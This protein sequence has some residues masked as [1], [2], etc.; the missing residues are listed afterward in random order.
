MNAIPRNFQS[1]SA[2]RPLG[3]DVDGRQSSPSQ[4]AAGHLYSR[5][6]F[7]ACSIA[8]LTGSGLFITTIGAH[9]GIATA[10]ILAVCAVASIICGCT[11]LGLR[12][13]GK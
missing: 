4:A 6:A 10:S 3:G 11:A 9:V 5:T 7:H 8:A 1:S 13:F 2:A 12:A